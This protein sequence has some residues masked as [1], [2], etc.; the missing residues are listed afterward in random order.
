M[1]R[2]SNFVLA[3]MFSGG[4]LV[5]GAVFG[6]SRHYVLGFNETS[7]LPNWA[8][9]IDKWNKDP[10]RGDYVSFVAPDNRYYPHGSV[11][12]KYVWGV[13]G[14]RV[15]LRGREFFVGDHDVGFAKL[16]SKTGVA[17]H[18]GPTGVIPFGRYYVGTPSKDSLDSR[19]A[20]IGW[21]DRARIVGV[22]KPVL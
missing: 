3:M 20:D 6:V 18:L 8:F 16:H 19:Y 15:S 17:T 22:A 2:P 4:L 14:D 21:I 5:A 13:A 7:S 10:R 12:V 9:V 1:R 11:F